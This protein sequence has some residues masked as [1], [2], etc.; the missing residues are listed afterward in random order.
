M[1]YGGNLIWTSVIKTLHERDGRPV[2]LVKVPGF[3][4]LIAGWLYDGATSLETDEIFRN[5]PRV[6]FPP[7]R[8]K[9]RLLQILDSL[10]FRAL[11]L[12]KMRNAYESFVF[13]SSEKAA[14]RGA[15]RL[16]HIDMRIHSY[17]ER[18]TAKRMIWKTQ[19]RAADA[20]LARFASS[21]ASEDCEIFLTDAEYAA[22]D[23]FVAR[24]GLSRGFVVV[25]PD[26][27]R[28][29]FG[30]LRA[31]PQER[32]LAFVQRMRAAHPALGIAQIGEP[33]GP[34]LPGV[35]DLRGK[36]DFRIACAL[37]KRSRLFVGT[38]GGLMHA[39]NAVG[40]KALILW[41]GVTMPEFAG[42]PLRQRTICK[43]VAC[44]PCGQLGWCDN[45]HICMQRISVDE[46]FVAAGEQLSVAD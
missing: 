26:T 24:E 11:D 17:A 6:V 39:A 15:L 1:G 19:P 35:V 18:Q 22:A 46:V 38:E 5:N 9:P 29:F 14:A 30:E 3:S 33:G 23:A 8:A 34:P 43:R 21:A 27:N 45:G 28:D 16:L 42:Y 20:V 10:F 2:G 13:F 40:A 31:W 25:E 36:T 7:V 41:G 4:D 37:L 32:W 44:S 12:L